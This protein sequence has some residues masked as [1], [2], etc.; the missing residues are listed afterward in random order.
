[1]ENGY[2]DVSYAIVAIK[3]RSSIVHGDV[4]ATI[5]QAARADNEAYYAEI[6]CHRALFIFHIELQRAICF[7]TI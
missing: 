4:H 1:M 3:A 5:M 2:A 7:R 6:T